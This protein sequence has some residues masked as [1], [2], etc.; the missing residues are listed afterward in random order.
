[1]QRRFFMKVTIDAN[2]LFSCLIKDSQTRKLFFSPELSI[3]APQFIS[4]ELIKYLP[5]LRAKSK[6]S[7]TEFLVL[8]DKI[9]GQIKIIPDKDLAPFLPAAASLLKDPKDLLYISCALSEDTIIWT[10]D[11][12]F[13]V[14]SRV[15]ALTTEELSQMVGTL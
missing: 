9:F 5:E 11:K 10:N 4:E 1:M 12:G 7:E 6:L 15:K 3:F 14:Q 13:K 2:I 8:L